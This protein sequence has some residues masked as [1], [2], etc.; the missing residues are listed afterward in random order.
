MNRLGQRWIAILMVLGLGLTLLSHITTYGEATPM[1]GLGS[2]S[3][4]F[5]YVDGDP[6]NNTDPTGLTRKGLPRNPLELLPLESGGGPGFGGPS[7]SGRSPFGAAPNQQR[8]SKF[9]ES[10][11]ESAVWSQLSTY[12][13]SIRSSGTSG[14][15]REYYEWDHTHG[16][17]EVFDRLGRHLGSMH[18]QTGVMHKPPVPGRTLNGR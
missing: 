11:S 12:R 5:V 2:D 4:S 9:C 18:P 8:Q 3:N 10:P 7:S 14:R 15:K 17:I 1:L 13:G 16:D 6:I